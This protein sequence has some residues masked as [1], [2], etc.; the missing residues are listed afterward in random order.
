MKQTKRIISI[1]ATVLALILLLPTALSAALPPTVSPMYENVLSVSCD[2]KFDST[3]NTLAAHIT[4]KPG[5]TIN[6][7]LT[8]YLVILG[9]N[10]VVQESYNYTATSVLSVSEVYENFMAGSIYKLQLSA[11]VTYNG[12]SETVTDEVTAMSP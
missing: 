10:E 3:P 8:L 4:G 11:T 9:R 2:I 12:V 1:T 5:C 7:T 6:A